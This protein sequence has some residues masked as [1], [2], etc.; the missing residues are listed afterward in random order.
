MTADGKSNTVEVIVVDTDTSFYAYNYFSQDGNYGYVVDVDM[1]DMSYGPVV[2]SPVDF[3]AADYN[4]HD[5]YYYGYTEGGQFWRYN[6]ATN[7]IDKLGEPLGYTPVDMAYNYST[8]LMYA[9]VTDYDMGYSTINLVN[10]KTGAMMPVDAMDFMI[11]LACD[12]N[13]DLYTVT[14]FGEV[15]KLHMD[16]TA[17]DEMEL[18]AEGFGEIQYMHSM[19]WDHEND[20]LLWP[21][22]EAGTVMWMDPESGSVLSLGDPT[23]AGLF[24]FVGMFTVPEDISEL[25]YVFAEELNVADMTMLVGATKFPNVEIK[26][27]N[28]TNQDLVL[29]SSDES[30]L[31][32]NEDG[33]MTAVSEGTVTVSVILNDYDP[34]CDETF[35]LKNAFQVNVIQGADQV[36][37]MVMT[38]FATNSGQY[39]IRIYTDNTSDPDMMEFTEYV[40]Y[41]EEYYNGN[42]YAVGYNPEEREGNWQMFVM[43]PKNHAIISQTDLGEGYPFV[44]DMTY[45]YTTSTMYAVA[46]PSDNDSEL[47]VFDMETGAL[48]LLMSTE[49]FFMSLAAGPDG[50]LYAMENSKEMAS[51]DDWF[52][53]LAPVEMGNAT[54]YAINPIEGTVELIGDTGVQCNHS[55]HRCEYGI[56]LDF[57]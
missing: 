47:Y 22:C 26:P 42:L 35:T 48:T 45:D 4:G 2:Q 16:D 29:D 30:I 20:V 25:P 11:T 14:A 5:G 10:L 44:Y 50:V 49:Q 13:G 33:S 6:I 8:G 39:W 19:C 17:I 28:A 51:E 31:K 40:I 1:G 7:E 27:Y 36:Y 38:D 57:L 52:D 24:E 54:L 55:A 18:I 32:I 15:Y 43:D 21:F 3:V 34:T 23:G 37:G 46:G 41:A 9:A 56:R 12:P 53:P